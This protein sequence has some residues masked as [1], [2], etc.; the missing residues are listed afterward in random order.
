MNSSPTILRFC[1][2]SDTPASRARKRFC[3]WTWTSGTWKWPPNVSTTWS[4]SFSRRRPWS[5]KTHVS[6]SPTAL[7]TSSAATAESTPPESAHRTRSRADRRAN[8]RD[9]LLDHGGGRPGGRRAGDLVEEVLQDLLAVRRVHDLRMELDAVELAR[10]ILERGDRRRGRGGG[11]V[12]ADRRRGDRV[13]VA[14]PDGL[15]GRQIV[16]EL[17]LVRLELRLPELGR[18]GALDG[19][20]EVSRHELHAVADAECRDPEREDA[21]VE[22]RRAVR[23]HRGGA[24]GED[25]RRRVSGRDLRCRQA[26]PDE[27]RVH[28]ASRTR[29]AISWL[30]WPP[31]STT[32]TGRS[33]GSASGVGSGTTFAISGGSS[34]RP[35]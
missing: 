10:A 34:A 23:V 8:A 14:H 7:W 9:L 13:A 26:V 20:A 6:W 17:G 22:I 15:L 25:E 28:A 1:S 31:R 4:A 33:S 2:G 12:S 29:R 18:A 27:L 21:G 16:E 19:A 30:Y 24:A 3:A 5:T 32:R 35:S 11:H